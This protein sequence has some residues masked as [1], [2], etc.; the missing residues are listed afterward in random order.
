[1]FLDPNKP[2]NVFSNKGRLEQCD[3]ALVAAL[4]GSLAVACASSDGAVI[5][6]Y[7]DLPKLANKK[8]YHKVFT[9]CP[10]IGVTYSGIQ[11]DFRIQ[12]DIAQ[13]LC[14]DYF[15][16]FGRYP[17]LETFI[18]E[19]SLRIQEY[20]QMGGSRPFGTYLLFIGS[21]QNINQVYRMDPS[22]SFNSCAVTATGKSYENAITFIER[23]Q[24][25]LDDNIAT[26]IN[27][28]KEYAGLKIEPEDI[29]VGIYKNNEFR[30]YTY[31]E[32]EELF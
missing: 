7:K 19:Y 22:G 29:S 21:G 20:S 4:N 27:A 25:E 26:C 3:N 31:N 8:N 1:M 28:I 5:M 10:T 16:V 9:V 13:R 6:S 24:S 14:L 12:L 30:I 15:E 23:R 11:P 18:N 2:F 32:I 17:T